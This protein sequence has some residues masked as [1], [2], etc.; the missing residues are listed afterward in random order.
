MKINKDL[1]DAIMM[2][3]FIGLVLVGTTDFSSAT[4]KQA[5]MGALGLVAIV[6]IVLRVIDLRRPARQPSW[7]DCE[8]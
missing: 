3:S 6:M 1:V 4:V 2:L 5:C 8:A 7:P